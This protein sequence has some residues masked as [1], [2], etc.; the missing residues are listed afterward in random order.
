MVKVDE[1]GAP[2][3]R[4]VRDAVDNLLSLG[5]KRAKEAIKDDERAAVV[6]VNVLGVATMVNTVMRRGIL[7]E[8]LSGK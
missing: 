3:L 2:R 8:E 1:E 5:L 6:L 7:K 4:H